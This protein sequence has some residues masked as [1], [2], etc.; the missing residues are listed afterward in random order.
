MD[1]IN[2]FS[3]LK[4]IADSKQLVE[5]N[6]HGAPTFKVGYILGSNEDFLT[7]AEVHSSAAYAGTIICRMED[8]ESIKT[9]TLYLAELVKRIKDDSIYS[10]AIEDTKNI[11]DNTFD[12]FIASFISTDTIVE[13][14]NT[15]EETYAGRLVGHDSDVLVLDEYYSEYPKRLAHTYLNKAYISRL[16]IS[17]PWLITISRSLVDKNL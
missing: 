1:Q 9:E 4:K 6:L 17:V 10:Q 8:I 2:Y 14:T 7:F 16:A 3:E 12:G 15:N 11:K 13:V 5:I